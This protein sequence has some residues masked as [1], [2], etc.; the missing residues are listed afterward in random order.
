[1]DYGELAAIHTEWVAAEPERERQKAV[2]QEWR[3]HD[4]EQRYASVTDLEAARE[5]VQRDKDR[6]S[7]MSPGEYHEAIWE[8]RLERDREKNYE[9]FERF[10]ANEVAGALAEYGP[11]GVT[12][13]EIREGVEWSLPQD[14]EVRKE[15]AEWFAGPVCAA[16]VAAARKV[17]SEPVQV[18]GP[19]TRG[20]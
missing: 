8:R 18:P 17:A 6:E 1:M 2:R 12:L 5:Q 11:D 15:V 7:G 9:E 16:L 3:W 13:D 20:P 4:M 14:D 10:C 19:G